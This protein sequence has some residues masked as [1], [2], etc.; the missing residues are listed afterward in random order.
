MQHPV[1]VILATVLLFASSPASAQFHLFNGVAFE[2]EVTPN[3]GYQFETEHR[4]IVNTGSENRVLF[5]G[6]INRQLGKLVSVTPGVRV[7]PYY[8]EGPTEVRLFTDFYMNFS[9]NDGPFTLEGRLRSQYEFELTDEASSAEIAIRPRIGLAYSA[10]RA[11]DLVGE[12]ET[13]YRFD[14]VDAIVQYRY[15]FGVSVALSTRVSVES[16][17]RLESDQL[18]EDNFIVGSVMVTYVLPD[19]RDRD[20]AYR[21]PFG[22]SL[23]W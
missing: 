7:T 18:P 5:T 9:P 14:N 22:R 15:T 8:G 23:L 2:H 1:W 4:Q 17:I 19:E 20:W 10:G 16:F 21:R 6:A 11:F 3:W 12:V 13:R